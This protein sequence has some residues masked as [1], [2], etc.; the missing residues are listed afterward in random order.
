MKELIRIILMVL[1]SFVVYV[2]STRQIDKKCET[3]IRQTFPDAVCHNV[4]GPKACDTNCKKQAE[5]KCGY[6]KPKQIRKLQCR[7]RKKRKGLYSCCCRV[8][9][10]S[11]LTRN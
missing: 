8:E 4:L 2:N 6:G 5:M 7:K 10:K 1:F 11:M 9:C 3:Q